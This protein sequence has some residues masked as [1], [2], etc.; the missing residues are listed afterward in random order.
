MPVS[1]VHRVCG[2][3]RRW[4]WGRRGLHVVSIF[5]AKQ[6]LNRKRLTL[7]LCWMPV[8]RV[9]RVC[10]RPGRWR[11]GRR[12]LR[13]VSTFDVKHALNQ[14]RLTLHYAGCLLVL[15][16]ECAGDQEGGGGAGGS[17]AV[18]DATN[19]LTTAG[20]ETTHRRTTL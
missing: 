16:I 14:K 17:G 15:S 7:Q 8:S 10:G 13:V 4:R 2:R 19:K 1:G 12:G 9:H 18:Q 3:P 20:P 6:A 11:R 5:D